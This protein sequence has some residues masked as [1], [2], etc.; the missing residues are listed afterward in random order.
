MNLRKGCHTRVV[1]SLRKSNQ[2]DM[3][4]KNG[5]SWTRSSARVSRR[6]YSVSSIAPSDAELSPLI[7]LTSPFHQQQS[8]ECERLVRPQNKENAPDS[9]LSWGVR[10][11]SPPPK[12]ALNYQKVVPSSY[13]I[14]QLA[15]L[16]VRQ[17]TISLS[18]SR[19]RSRFVVG[20]K[21]P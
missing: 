14:R 6:A 19:S 1:R 13:A 21:S 18:Y 5:K 8:C 16:P 9:D 20:E 15:K 12:S 17:I 2:R 10:S 7:V 3:S 11:S 4:E